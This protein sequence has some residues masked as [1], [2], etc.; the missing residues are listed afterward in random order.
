MAYRERSLSA[1]V[2]S[3][4][5]SN[6]LAVSTCRM[7]LQGFSHQLFGFSLQDYQDQTGIKVDEV[8]LT[9]RGADAAVTPVACSDRCCLTDA[10]C[11]RTRLLQACLTKAVQLWLHI[12]HVCLQVTAAME[13]MF[14]VFGSQRPATPEQIAAKDT[15]FGYLERALKAV[16]QWLLETCTA[17]MSHPWSLQHTALHW[18]S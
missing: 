11:S 16:I 18:C 12:Q 6:I 3:T 9:C 15:V 10:A 7:L 8:G 13:E 2:V 17:Q 1:F 5:Q 4:W 14:T